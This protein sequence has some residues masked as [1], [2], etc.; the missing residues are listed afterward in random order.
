[1]HCKKRK[2]VSL[3]LIKIIVSKDKHKFTME[4]WLA[5]KEL[6]KRHIFPYKWR[7]LQNN[8][9]DRKT[10]FVYN[11]LFFDDLLSIVKD[12]FIDDPNYDLY[13][14]YCLNRW[15]NFWS[16][17]AVEKIFC[18]HRIVQPAK[19]K[20]DR[21]VDFY[22]ND[23]PFDLKMTVFPKAYEH[24]LMNVKADPLPL[25]KWLYEN[26]SQQGRKHLSNRLFLVL[27][28]QS[29][30]HWKL[31][32]EINWLSNIIQNYVDNYQKDALHKLIL[33]QNNITLSDLI[34]A[35]KV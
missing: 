17:K 26:Q 31:K 24:Y 14:D 35:Q 10:N 22:I 2:T 21:Y 1:M 33:I 7:Q 29:G 19:N 11:T 16:A 13:F 28:N 6:K 25:I 27:H 32:A 15:Y 23:T 3:Y 5:E 20:K 12:L 4:V 9:F 18:S 34:L 30:E 8:N